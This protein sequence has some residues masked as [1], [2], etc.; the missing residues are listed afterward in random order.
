MS[1][2]VAGRGVGVGLTP[3]VADLRAQ[4]TYGLAPHKEILPVFAGLPPCSRGS[5]KR[6]GPARPD[7]TASPDTFAGKEN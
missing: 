7:V 1:G 3:E 2:R 4:P 5:G 6:P